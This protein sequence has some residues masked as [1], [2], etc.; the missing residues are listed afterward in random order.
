M[1]D[2]LA[3]ELFGGFVTIARR[4]RQLQTPGELTLPERASL[5]RLEQ[6]GPTTAAALARAEQVTPQAMGTTLS[7]LES[8]GLVQ[9]RPDPADGR[10]VVLSLTDSGADILR[11][12]HDT[13][14]RQFAKA[15]EAE[16][17]PA[18]RR[19]LVA[20]APLLERLGRHI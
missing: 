4:V 12:K 3:A 17:T 8:R 6:G 13:R 11:H 19:T 5:A 15:L 16:F 14:V 7:A 2:T 20:A 9:R 18:E 10:R 1:S